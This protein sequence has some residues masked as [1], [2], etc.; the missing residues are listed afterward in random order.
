MRMQLKVTDSTTGLSDKDVKRLT[1]IRHTVPR[2]FRELSGLLEN[3]SGV[4]ELIFGPRSPI[5][6]MLTSWVRFLTRTGG[7]TVALLRQMAAVDATMPSRLGWFI[8]RRL[9]QFLVACASCDHIDLVDP[10][11]FDFTLA[12]QQLIDGMFQFPICPYIKAKLGGEEASAAGAV[13]SRGGATGRSGYADDVATRTGGWSRSQAR[14]IGRLLWTTR[15]RP[16]SPIYAA[17][18]I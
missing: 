17:G 6:T 5:T 10:G 2:D 15:A 7:T 13:S 16:Q 11:L 3:M 8:E 9:Q 4:A 12:R 18:T 14:T 1:Q